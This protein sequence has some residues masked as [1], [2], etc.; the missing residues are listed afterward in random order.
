MWFCNFSYPKNTII[1]I[2]KS[3]CICF[4]MRIDFGENPNYI[5]SLFFDLES[6]DICY[7]KKSRFQVPKVKN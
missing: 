6:A 5:S 1:I 7:L 4:D 3:K 2:A